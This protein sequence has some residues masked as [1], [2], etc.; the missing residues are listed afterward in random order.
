MH[1]QLIKD[2]RHRYIPRRPFIIREFCDLQ[3]EAFNEVIE[4]GGAFDVVRCGGNYDGFGLFKNSQ[5]G[6]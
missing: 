2:P 4:I 1:K 3:C 6:A 5:M